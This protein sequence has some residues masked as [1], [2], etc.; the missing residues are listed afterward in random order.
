MTDNKNPRRGILGDSREVPY[1]RDGAWLSGLRR[2][3]Q[4]WKFSGGSSQ[5][6]AFNPGVYASSDVAS[7]D[8]AERRAIIALQRQLGTGSAFVQSGASNCGAGGDVIILKH[9]TE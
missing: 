8:F 5:R 7:D 1:R 4:R 2:W 3:W 9:P 6:P